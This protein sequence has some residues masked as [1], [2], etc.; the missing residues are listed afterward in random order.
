MEQRL[1]GKSGIATS[2]IGLDGR[3]LSGEYGPL[4]N[5]MAFT[6]LAEAD[7]SGISFWNTADV[8]GDG[9]SET[10]AGAWNAFNPANRVIATKVGRNNELYPGRHQYD[11][12]RRSL[13]GSLQRMNVDCLELVQLHQ[14]DTQMLQ[15]DQ[16]WRWLEDFRAEGLLR[17][18]GVSVKTPEQGL[19]CLDKPGLTS[20]EIVF[21]LF[22]QE[23]AET[24]L[25]AAAKAGVGI[26]ACQPLASGLL[27]DKLSALSQF[28]ARDYR[29]PS[30]AESRAVLGLPYSGFSLPEGL[31]AV[32]QLKALNLAPHLALYQLAL[33]WVLDHREVSSAVV[34]VSSYEQLHDNAAVAALPPLSWDIH[35]RLRELPQHI[36][37]GSQDI[38]VPA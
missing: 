22:R 17:H 23:A 38:A 16:V 26:I 12:M 34:G 11:R 18:Y 10:R 13:E 27:A 9:L 36:A 20:I 6:V 21:N 5:V 24:L 37:L 32:E 25:P 8:Y 29:N 31:K 35:Q 1:L 33:R 14:L 7:R 15:G 28:D 2:V 3:S 4:D 19:L 30:N